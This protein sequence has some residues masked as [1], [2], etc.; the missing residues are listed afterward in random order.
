M[1]VQFEDAAAPL[2]VGKGCKRLDARRASCRIARRRTAHGYLVDAIARLGDGADRAL[3]ASQH[4][5]HG[6][7]AHRWRRGAG[8]ADRQ[9]GRDPGRRH[10]ADTLTG[11]PFADDAG[12]RQGRGHAA[13]RRT[14]TTSCAAMRRSATPSAPDVLDGGPGRDRVD[15][16]AVDA[17]IDLA[18]P[19]GPG[20]DQLI[21]IEGVSA[22]APALR[23]DA[24][25][26][27]ARGRRRA[28]RRRGR[29][30][31][32]R[33]HARRRRRRRRRARARQATK[34]S[35]G[36]GDRHRRVRARRPQGDPGRVRARHAARASSTSRCALRAAPRRA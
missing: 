35:C 6:G 25:R 23:G 28:V 30:H 8:H 17:P 19:T 32:V 22:Y 12:G 24:R 15:Y 31:V 33:R 26:Q 13:R 5:S 4:P 2:T 11:S 27:R 7:G 16:D 21:G 36:A 14:V 9:R 1:R 34:F 29:R 20:G 3:A 18:Q 10:G